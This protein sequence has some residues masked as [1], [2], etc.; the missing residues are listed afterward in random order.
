LLV[1]R[2]GRFFRVFHE[3][4]IVAGRAT[5]FAASLAR[6]AATAEAFAAAH[7]GLAFAAVRAL[8]ARLAART[9]ARKAH[10][11]AALWFA[12]LQFDAGHAG[13]ANVL[14]GG[15]NAHFKDGVS[16]YVLDN[17]S[18]DVVRLLHFV[19]D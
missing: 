4:A 10:E 6:A 5:H 2:V 12:A 8:E 1:D 18:R 13:S 11:S 7:A 16:L 9:A 15:T 17:R 14:V 3:D 19:K